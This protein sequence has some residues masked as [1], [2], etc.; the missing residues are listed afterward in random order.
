MKRLLLML[1]AAVPVIALSGC[2]GGGGGVYSAG[3]FG[4]DGFYDDYY[5]PIYD[6]Y[7]GGDGAFYYRGSAGEHRYRRGDPAHF[8]R[9]TTPLGHFHEMHGSMS[10]APHVRMPHFNAGGPGSAGPQQ[11]RHGHRG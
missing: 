3:S 10:P 1:S 6:G 9:G 5:G 11:G 2:Y 8:A 4:Y 7:W